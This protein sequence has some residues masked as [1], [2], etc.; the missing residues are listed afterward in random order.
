MC[1]VSDQGARFTLVFTRLVMTI[2]SLTY[3][4]IAINLFNVR[5]F[6]RYRDETIGRTDNWIRIGIR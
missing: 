4:V 1:V 2:N 5:S 3:L 6:L